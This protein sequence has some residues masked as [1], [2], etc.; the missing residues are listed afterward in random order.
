MHMWLC[1]VSFGLAQVF[2]LW[3]TQIIS[4]FHYIYKS[5]N[6]NILTKVSNMLDNNWD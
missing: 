6:S 2:L 1:D 4:L 3:F 5:F